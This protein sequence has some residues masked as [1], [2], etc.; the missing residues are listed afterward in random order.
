MGG[1]VRCGLELR[2][3]KTRNDASN[4]FESATYAIEEL[5]HFKIEA[6]FG[7]DAGVS[8]EIEAHVLS[9]LGKKEVGS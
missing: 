2:E 1:D 9:L 3:L 6:V 8:G 5:R 4:A 7:E